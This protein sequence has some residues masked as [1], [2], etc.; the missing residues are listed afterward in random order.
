MGDTNDTSTTATIGK[1]ITVD[2]TKANNSTV[3]MAQSDSETRYLTVKITDGDKVVPLRTTD[4]IFFQMKSP[5]NNYFL[6]ECKN[7]GD[8]TCTVEFTANMLASQGVNNAQIVIATGEK[9]E[10]GDF[11]KINTVLST[12][13]FRIYIWE[14]ALSG[15]EQSSDFINIMTMQSKMRRE[16]AIREDNENTRI[17]NEEVR[18]ANDKTW[19]ENEE[20]RKKNETNRVTAETAREEAEKTREE[21]CNQ[22][23]E[24]EAKRQEAEK[25]RVEAEETRQNNEDT[26]EK[27]EASR[28]TA[29]N[30]RISNEN[31]RHDNEIKRADA[32]TARVSAEQSRVNEYT[33]LKHDIQATN[34]VMN[35]NEKAREKAEDAR[36]TAEESREKAEQVRIEAE[37]ERDSDEHDRLK[38]EKQRAT[39]EAVRTSNEEVRRQNE[40]DRISA[41]RERV[42]N[43]SQRQTNES[44]RI[45][46]TQDMI[47]NGN[48]IIQQVSENQGDYIEKTQKAANDGVASLNSNGKVP[49]AQLPG[50]FV[51]TTYEGKAQ[52]IT[53]SAESDSTYA[54][55]FI[56]DGESIPCTPEDDAVYIDTDH[57]ITFRWTGSRFVSIDSFGIGETSATAFAG[58][59]GKELEKTVKAVKKRQASIDGSPQI[60]Y[61]KRTWYVSP[62][63]TNG[64]NKSTEK[65]DGYVYFEG[66]N[67][68]TKQYDF[69]ETYPSDQYNIEQLQPYGGS[70]EQVKAFGEAM[71]VGS[72]TENILTALG[73]LPTIDI[74][75]MFYVKKKNFDDEVG[76]D[77][78]TTTDTATN[79]LDTT[80]VTTTTDS[81]IANS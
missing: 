45:S 67:P 32:E 9:D 12:A 16:E 61:L 65:L 22:C 80:P 66:W 19:N 31:D 69:R 35:N 4:Y 64:T 50:S 72:P 70:K 42:S 57:N 74:Q 28:K 71:I 48:N 38:A 36:N 47:A 75:V 17:K 81:S 2:T 79:A 14:S 55:A 59:R 41:E 51:S 54:T 23:A 11:T 58:D 52:N 40:R 8:D 76:E 49:V 68:D 34:D 1:S 5:D 44:S 13:T 53:K 77:G 6:K 25:S 78:G 3:R 46:E 29:E 26:R 20:T 60:A 10:N 63:D 43:E 24:E 56:K 30:S 37:A 18:T 39:D 15:V 62:D 73:T 7:N 33:I 21:K 27:N